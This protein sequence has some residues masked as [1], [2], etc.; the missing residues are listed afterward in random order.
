[1]SNRTLEYSPPPSPSILGFRWIILTLIF[2]GTT[3]NYIDR[4]VLSLVAPTIKHNFGITA[5]QYGYISAAWA[6]AYAFG[7]IFSGAMLDKIGTRLGYA[8]ALFAWS[9]CA[10]LTALSGGFVSFAIYRAM[11]GVCESPAY[12]A[13]A[14]VCAEWFPQRQR[15][16]AFGWVNAG[17]NMAAIIT[18]LVVPPLA[19]HFGWQSAFI[20]TGGMGMLLLVAWVPLYRQ[21]EKHPLVSEQELALILSDPPQS[22]VKMPWSEVIQHRQAWVF[23]AG[24]MFTDGIWW[25]FLTWVPLFFFDPPYNL[26]LKNIGWPLV[27]IYLMAD[28]GSVVGG[29]LSSALMGFGWSTNFSRKMAMLICGACTVPIVFAPHMHREWATVLIIGMAV[30][31][32][33]GY[34]SNL[35]TVVSDLFPKNVVASIAGLGGFCGYVGASIFQVFTGLWVE[36]T[37]NYQAPFFC[38]AI[39]YVGSVAIMHAISPDFRPATV[40]E[41]DGFPVDVMPIAAEPVVDRD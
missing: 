31:G 22:A 15:S 40:R 34:S 7:Q 4:L 6:I 24:K 41:P 29:A 8:M 14:K 30:S 11:L 3:I 27:V 37:H 19:L 21:P 16:F 13:A 36:H 23:I 1:L 12:P 39:T 32:H 33:Q 38:A 5:S 17:C 25:F 10:M 20:W 26:D 2:L 35:Y 28:V 18:P 9:I